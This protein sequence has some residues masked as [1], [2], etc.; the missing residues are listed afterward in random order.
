MFEESRR[1]R[2]LQRWRVWSNVAMLVSSLLCVLALALTAA[3]AVL[4]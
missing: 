2:R 4:R 3:Q 1:E